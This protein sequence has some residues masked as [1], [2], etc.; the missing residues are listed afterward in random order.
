MDTFTEPQGPA[1]LHLAP[2]TLPSFYSFLLSSE[3][4]M[5]VLK[6]CKAFSFLCVGPYSSSGQDR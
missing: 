1:G 3:P 2:Q 4:D 6:M 5:Q